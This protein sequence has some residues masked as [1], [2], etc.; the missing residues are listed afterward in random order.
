MNNPEPFIE[1][2]FP[3]YVCQAEPSS[4]WNINLEETLPCVRWYKYHGFKKFL[5]HD[6][7]FNWI[8]VIVIGWK[9]QVNTCPHL[10]T[11]RNPGGSESHC[12][13]H[14]LDSMELFRR[15]TC[16]IKGCTQTPTHGFS[17]QPPSFCKKH[18]PKVAEKNL[19]NIPVSISTVNADKTLR[20]HDDKLRVK[21]WGGSYFVRVEQSSQVSGIQHDQIR[22]KVQTTF[23]EGVAYSR[24]LEIWSR[25]DKLFSD[26]KKSN[27]SL[28]NRIG[29]LEIKPNWVK[30]SRTSP[31]ETNLTPRSA[32][33]V[34]GDTSQYNS[35][36]QADMQEL[37]KKK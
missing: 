8:E 18:A 26:E 27:S 1:I 28:A 23:G 33:F 37:E 4:S 30:R 36:S 21:P 29:H 11:H 7:K 24:R 5:P 31:F 9:C 19:P 10:A 3:R 17:G 32:H 25:D 15:A 20:N 35:K 14:K 16:E 6:A 12:S 2:F 22:L 34:R 13:K